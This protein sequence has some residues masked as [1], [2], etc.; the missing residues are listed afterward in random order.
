M[1]ADG[2][3]AAPYRET[4]RD[5]C[6]GAGSTTW[7]PTKSL[8]MG[9]SMDRGVVR[10]AVRIEDRAYGASARVQA[11]FGHTKA[12]ARFRLKASKV[13]RICSPARARPR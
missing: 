7:M 13:S 10:A 12:A 11:G 9:G 6:A 5:L 4:N 8:S 1:A 3:N 2:P